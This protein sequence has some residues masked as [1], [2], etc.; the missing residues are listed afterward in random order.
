MYS[1]KLQVITFQ[2]AS[3]DAIFQYIKHTDI[4]QMMQMRNTCHF[5]SRKKIKRDFGIFDYRVI[6]VYSND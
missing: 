1:E 4:L 2:S 5:A 3:M 6:I